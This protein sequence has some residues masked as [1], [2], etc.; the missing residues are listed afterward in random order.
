QADQLER[1]ATPQ[2]EAA[3]RVADAEAE[4][5]V[6]VEA[7]TAAEQAPVEPP[8]LGECP[9][10]HIPA[11]DDQAGLVGQRGAEHGPDR[12]GLVAGV[13]VHVY[14]VRVAAAQRLAQPGQVG[15]A[16]AV[17][18]RAVQHDHPVRGVDVGPLGQG[19]GDIAG[20][21]GGVVVDHDNA[22]VGQAEGE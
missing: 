19:V 12:V 3:G 20:S 17:L 7:A 21:V 1:V 8:A 6:D 15:P 2:L 22:Q 4:H 9:A 11:A 5:G 16:D 18:P 10:G 14:D 13:G